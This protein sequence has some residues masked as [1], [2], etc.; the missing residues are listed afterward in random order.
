MTSVPVTESKAEHGDVATISIGSRKSQ[1]AL[2]Q[3]YYV[4]DRLKEVYPEREF[5]VVKMSTTGDKVLD[6]ALSKI[7]E[8]S[9][10]TKELEVALEN[11]TV[12]LVVHS[13][14]D[15]PTT[16]PPGMVIGAIL[17]REDPRDAVVLAERFQGLTLED[18]PEASVIGTSSVRRIAQ[19]KAKYP[20]FNFQDIRGNLNTRLAKLDDPNGPYAAIILAVAGL[21]RMGWESRISQIMVESDMLHAVGQ[22]ALGIECREGDERILDLLSFLNHRDTRL[23]CFAERGFMRKLE[24]GCSVPIGVTTEWLDDAGTPNRRLRLH[25]IVSSPDGQ[26]VIRDQII[27]EIGDDETK[28]TGLGEHLAELFISKGAERILEPLK[29]IRK[30]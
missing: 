11:H 27:E 9:L 25:G 8:K 12:D 13:L 26:E 24:G 16:L 4:R 29:N 20:Q 1:L 2:I 30:W 17:E 14:K 5:P 19:L 7:G 22:G 3:T 18:L 28:A 6:V 21:K 23:S 10:F 15:L